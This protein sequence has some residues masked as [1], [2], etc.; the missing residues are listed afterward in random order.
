MQDKKEYVAF[1]RTIA[2]DKAA[3]LFA[4]RFCAN[5]SHIKKLTKKRTGRF[6]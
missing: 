2:V 6:L 3:S 1:S 4:D 5:R